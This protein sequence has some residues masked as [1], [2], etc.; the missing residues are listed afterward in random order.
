MNV[1]NS[2]YD[3]VRGFAE[4]HRKTVDFDNPRDL[5]DVYLKEINST[6]DKDSSFYKEEGGRMHS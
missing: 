2:T 1:I 4:E 5:I 3:F 6:T